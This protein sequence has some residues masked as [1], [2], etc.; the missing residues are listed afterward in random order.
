MIDYK[1]TLVSELETLGLPVHY[2][3]FIN[4]DT[5]VPCISYQEG[6]NITHKDG[7]TLGYS[8]INFRIKI[9]AKRESEIAQYSLA[10]DSLMRGLGFDR[11][12]TSEL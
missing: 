3:L 2:E 6:L 9:W 5:E 7:D 11:I 4:K 8:Y 12:A 1:P 10:I